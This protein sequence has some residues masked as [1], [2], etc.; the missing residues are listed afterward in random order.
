MTHVLTVYRRK[1]ALTLAALG[2]LL[3]VTKGMLSK[4]ETGKAFPRA[5]YIARIHEIT[6]GQITANDML[7]SYNEGQL[8][9]PEAAE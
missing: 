6:D 5:R 4:W 7:R 8:Q 1:N 3:G 2:S 9:K